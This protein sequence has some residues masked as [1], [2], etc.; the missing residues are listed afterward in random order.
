MTYLVHQTYYR[1][2]GPE[3]V[4]RLITSKQALLIE[5]HHGKQRHI[6]DPLAMADK[7]E[8]EL[9]KLWLQAA[10]DGRVYVVWALRWMRTE[11]LPPVMPAAQPLPA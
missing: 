7:P 6:E 2:V 1:R 11:E 4:D 8:D 5:D 3:E 9:R 10:I